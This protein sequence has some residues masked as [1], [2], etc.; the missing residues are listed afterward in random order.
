MAISFTP[1]DARTKSDLFAKFPG[2]MQ[3]RLG[4]LV[5]FWMDGKPFE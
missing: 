1:T 2:A 5:F 4:I 3:A